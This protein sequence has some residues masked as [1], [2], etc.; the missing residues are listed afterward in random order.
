MEATDIRRK[1]IKKDDFVRYTGTGSIGKVLDI[2]L[3]SSLDIVDKDSKVAISSQDKFWIKID[4]TDLW[5]LSDSLE[6]LD[7]KD[8]R[9]LGFKESRDKKNVE[10]FANDFE[11]M[12][13]DSNAG[14]GGG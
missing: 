7:E 14:I 8:I 1:S 5:Y 13:I 11:D 6:L 12:E 3:Y 4:K 9:K 10:E 2:L